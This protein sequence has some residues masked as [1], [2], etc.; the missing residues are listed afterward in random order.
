MSGRPSSGSVTTSC[1][2]ARLS[3]C[4]SR[5]STLKSSARIGS[6]KAVV[7]TVGAGA[8][9]M[10]TLSGYCRDTY[11]QCDKFPFEVNRRI[12]LGPRPIGNTRG[13]ESLY[14]EWDETIRL[15]M[16]GKCC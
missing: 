2:A 16:Y 8:L 5:R 15:E 11:A 9:L 14:R 10:Q 6:S 1:A 3:A 13:V 7:M 4:C 12:L